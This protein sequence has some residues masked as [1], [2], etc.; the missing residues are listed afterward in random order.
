MF[1][2]SFFCF[3]FWFAVT[4]RPYI[5]Q[6]TPSVE[7]IKLILDYKNGFIKY[8]IHVTI[9][10]APRYRAW[11]CDRFLA[12]RVQIQPGAWSVSLV[13]AA[14]CQ[15]YVFTSGRS[16]V[17]RSRTECGF[18]NECNCE[19]SIM[20]IPCPIMGC[21]VMGKTISTSFIFRSRNKQL[22]TSTL[23]NCSAVANCYVYYSVCCLHYGMTISL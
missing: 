19:V 16:L 23:C 2:R 4:L 21:C 22:F 12:L 6:R 14:C 13:S 9:P 8:S 18:Y 1:V 5:W 7:K 11:V 3:F 20:R 10:V 17:Q 15:I